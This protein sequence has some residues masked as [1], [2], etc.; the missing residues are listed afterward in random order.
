MLRELAKAVA[1]SPSLSAAVENEYVQPVGQSQTVNGI[2]ATVEYVIV[3]MKQL[4]IYYTL[5]SRQYPQ[6]EASGDVLLPGEP[7][8]WSGGSSSF[9]T[10]NGELRS[11]RLDFIERDIPETLDFQLKAY[12]GNSGEEL[13]VPVPA[14]EDDPF[15]PVSDDPE[16][17]AEFTFPLELDPTFTAKGEAIPVNA[18]FTLDGHT[19]SITE[20]EVYPTHMRLNLRTDPGN[21]AWLTGLEFYMEDETGRRFRPTTNGILSSGMTGGSDDSTV[22]LDSPYFESSRHL[23]LHIT[24]AEWLDKSAPRVRLD[25]RR[26]TAENLPEDIRFLKA[27]ELSGGWIVSF[28]AGIKGEHTMFGLFQHTFWDETGQEHDITQESSTY[29]YEDP[30]TGERVDDGSVFTA[31]FPLAGYHG[32]TAYLE[33]L[34]NSASAFETPVAV[35]IK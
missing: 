22:W 20:A 31:E 15:V 2:T 9:G 32:D 11:F 19:V 8:G 28:A 30:S 5:D 14:G 3:D 23:T 17:L 18:V 26:G 12:A 6:L 25:L 4:N 24:G 13:A 21:D 7:G 33:P 29:G 27:E 35:S 1:W 34:F 16:Y 10:P